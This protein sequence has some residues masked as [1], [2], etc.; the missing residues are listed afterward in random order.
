MTY[1]LYVYTL[2]VLGL[3]FAFSNMYVM[4]KLASGQMIVTTVLTLCTFAA[5]IG[6]CFLILYFRIKR[7]TTTSETVGYLILVLVTG[8]ISAAM[9]L[10]AQMNSM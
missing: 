1:G 10:F 9:T 3:V 2:S 6:A 8:M 4:S 7:L 5:L